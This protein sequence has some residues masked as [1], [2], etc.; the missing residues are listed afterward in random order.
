MNVRFHVSHCWPVGVY[1][2]RERKIETAIA[3]ALI[4]LL[5][6]FISALATHRLGLWRERKARRA[7]AAAQFRNA[8]MAELFSVYPI[9]GAWP[10][11]IAGFFKARFDALQAAIQL[12]RP[13]VPDKAAFDDAWLRFYCAYP[14]KMQEQC[15]HHYMSSYDPAFGNQ[16]AADRK[17]RGEL[18]KNVTR[19]LA[20]A[21]E[22]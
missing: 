11:D 18:H 5:G 22:I 8:V 21:D 12:F 20:F 9:P 19:L 1:P 10:N 6:V 16:E 3:V 17:A 13:Y 7:T 14:D 2:Q 15:Y 4:A